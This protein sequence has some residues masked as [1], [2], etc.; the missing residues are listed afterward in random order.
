M[1]TPYGSRGGMAFSA[2][3]LRVLRG[4]LAVALQSSRASA[5]EVREVLQLTES[6]DEAEREG[7]RLRSFL[8]ADLARYRA[9]LPG[10]A[11]GYLDLLD[12]ALAAG[13]LPRPE[14]LNALRTLA[15]APAGRT[16]SER[17]A[18]LLR[19]CESLAEQVVRGRLLVLPG[20]R[21]AVRAEPDLAEE[22]PKRDPKKEPPKEPRREPAKPAPQPGRRPVPTPGE[23]F[24][25]RRRPS[26]TPPE[27]AHALPA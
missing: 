20:G 8:L 24:P 14:D 17:R 27:E 13:Y 21:A 23:V 7:H 25:P 6:L 11:G 15:R 5:W 18:E 19:R 3:E 16:A 2:D 26:T 12:G 10:T 22:K 9:A 4:A 1:P